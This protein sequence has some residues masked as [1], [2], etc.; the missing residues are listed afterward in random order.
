M[1]AA[2]PA[3]LQWILA[4]SPKLCRLTK[5]NNWPF[6]RNLLRG[7]STE[8]LQ[9]WSTRIVEFIRI[10]HRSFVKRFSYPKISYT[11]RKHDNSAECTKEY[12]WLHSLMGYKR[13]RP[14]LFNTKYLGTIIFKA[15]ATRIKLLWEPMIDF[16]AKH[17][18]LNGIGTHKTHHIVSLFVP[19]VK[20]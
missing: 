19:V 13:F 5:I 11:W 9:E 14:V 10:S 12:S 1:T 20:R 15:D 16:D 7:I 2:V 4:Y 6:T 8:G 3:V 17:T 18:D